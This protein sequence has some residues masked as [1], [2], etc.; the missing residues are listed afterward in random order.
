MWKPKTVIIVEG[1]LV[2]H[3]P[4]LRD[5]LDI[6]IYVDA[7]ADER[8]LRRTIRDVNER[9]QNMDDIMKQYLATVKPMHYL[10]M[11]PTKALAD[12][13]LNSG[14]NAIALDLIKT[15]ID[16]IVSR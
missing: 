2:F 16:E 3:D 4:E 6:K 7:D 1:I 14:M 11:E 12:I 15:K 9:G 13:V 10:Y 5:M 8:I